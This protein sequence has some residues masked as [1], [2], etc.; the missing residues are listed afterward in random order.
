MNLLHFARVINLIASFPPT[1]YYALIQ[2]FFGWPP[3]GFP[4]VR[5][6]DPHKR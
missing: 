4:K 3:H 5:S 1:H 6:P 2:L